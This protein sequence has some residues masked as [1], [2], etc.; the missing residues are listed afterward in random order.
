MC[1]VNIDVAKIADTEVAKD[2]ANW[3]YRVIG[4][5]IEDG[6]GL[7]FADALK[8]RRLR[9][10]IRLQTET[11]RYKI[12]QQ[13]PIPLSFGY[14]LLDKATLEESDSLISKWAQLLVNSLDSDYNGEIRK[15][16]IDILDSL[17]PIDAKVLEKIAEN[18]EPV[19]P[20][21]LFETE[22]KTEISI[23][24]DSL[25]SLNL[26]MEDYDEQHVLIPPGDWDDPTD[27]YVRGYNN[28]E[29]YLTDLGR[30][31][32]NSVNR[33]EHTGLKANDTDEKQTK[34]STQQ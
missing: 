28:G 15:I 3:I 8:E 6:V 1:K 2:T 21:K 27:S 32:I 30:S 17:E 25:K 18:T 20:L 22:K 19:D 4:A 12:E 16:Y 10:A 33:I 11:L 23:S 14:K 24:V 5:P 31:F 13:K 29:F 9:N 7:L 34:S 26:I